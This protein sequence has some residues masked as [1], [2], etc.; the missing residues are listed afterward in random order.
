MD[1][2]AECLAFG[3]WTT[4]AY[5]A[6]RAAEKELREY[7]ALVVEEPTERL[8]MEQAIDQLRA[9][10]ADP[11]TLAIMDQLQT[12]IETPS[13][14]QRCSS[15]EQKQWNCSR[16]VPARSAVVRQIIGLK[17]PKLEGTRGDR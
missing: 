15:T 3:I 7:Y 9:K 4:S 2:Q 12:Y 6:L 8:G 16:S 5:H 13:T 1:E 14:I 10:G 11:K 17:K